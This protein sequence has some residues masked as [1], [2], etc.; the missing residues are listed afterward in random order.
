MS[1]WISVDD[2]LPEKGIVLVSNGE[3]VRTSHYIQRKEFDGGM[4]A[5]GCWAETDSGFYYKPIT[6][7]MPLPARPE[8]EK[9]E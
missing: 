1:D 4:V 3:I 7:W 5:G 2:R 8:Q 6:H 9:Q